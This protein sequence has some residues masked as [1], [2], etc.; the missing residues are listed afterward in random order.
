MSAVGHEVVGSAGP[1]DSLGVPFK[2]MVIDQG[3]LL[4]PG[5]A[6]AFEISDQFL[7]FAV[8]ADDRALR[9]LEALTLVFD[10]VELLVAVRVG[11][12]GLFLVIDAQRIVQALEQ[13]RHRVGTDRDSRAL[14]VRA[15][16]FGGSVRPF[17]AAHGVA[18]GI[19]GH[20]LF[21]G[22]QDFGVFFSKGGRPAPARRTGSISR[23]RLRSSSRP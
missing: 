22:R 17:Q 11:C 18:G 21:Q 8:H 5:G 14:E 15:E 23:S 2:I 10:V 7:L 6:G 20:R 3:G 19:V 16:L 12:A 4:G 9:R 13:P 1:S